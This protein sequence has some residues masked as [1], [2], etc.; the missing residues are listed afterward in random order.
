MEPMSDAPE[1]AVPTG[2]SEPIGE[3]VADHAAD[4]GAPADDAS[5]EPAEARAHP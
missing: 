2:E 3:P 5:P 4:L 1:E